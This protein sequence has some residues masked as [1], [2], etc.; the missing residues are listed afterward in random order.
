[1]VETCLF[2]GGA[3]AASM[4]AREMMFGLRHEFTY[5]RC[6]RCLSLWLQ[7]PPASLSP[8]YGEGYYSMT[9]DPK[10]AQPVR[11]AALWLRLLLRLPV[12]ACDRLAGR[13]GFP[14][15]I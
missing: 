5:C 15:Y 13:R 6:V 1:M 2:C 7:D 12:V 11:G 8:Y 10:G 3:S 14:R 9:A 4:A